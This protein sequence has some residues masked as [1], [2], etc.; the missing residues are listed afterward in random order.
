MPTK[1]EE[2]KEVRV[3]DMYKE[4]MFPMKPNAIAVSDCCR[5]H[6]TS[7]VK[8]PNGSSYWRCT[9][10]Y[11]QID[12]NTTGEASEMVFVRASDLPN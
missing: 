11:G 5:R 1:D 10:H 8:Y 2:L 12:K 4:C 6:A 3:T 9:A 7:V